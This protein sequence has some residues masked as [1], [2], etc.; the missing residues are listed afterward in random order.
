MKLNR[1]L[2]GFHLNETQL[3]FLNGYSMMI[4]YWPMGTSVYVAFF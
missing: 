1:R 4:D 3:Q 2:C